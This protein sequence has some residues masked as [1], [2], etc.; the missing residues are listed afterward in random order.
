MCLITGP[1]RAVSY[2]RD[3]M[4]VAVRH[5]E[6]TSPIAESY[7]PSTLAGSLMRKLLVST[8]H[9]ADAMAQEAMSRPITRLGLH[10]AG[11][12]PLPLVEGLQEPSMPLC[13]TSKAYVTETV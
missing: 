11:M 6:L 12:S 4:V 1:A 8:T 7:S 10:S 3:I 5:S 9:C 2:E 13:C